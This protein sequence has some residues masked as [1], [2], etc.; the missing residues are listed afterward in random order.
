MPDR[1]SKQSKAKASSF[2]TTPIG[3]RELLDASPDAIFCVDIEGRCNWLSPAIESL[4]GRKPGDLIGHSCTE[5]VA[6]ASR[7]RFLRVFLRQRAR[8]D[9]TTSE[10]RLWVLRQD[11]GQTAVAV[12][13][14][15]VERIDG[16]LVFGECCASR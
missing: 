11:G 3:L 2:A 6:P 9:G 7:S 1:P 12:R 5:L 14:R 15:L 13:V 10:H 4:T 8:K 16:D